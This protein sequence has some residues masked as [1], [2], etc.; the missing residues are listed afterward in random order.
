M[1]LRRRRVVIAAALL[2]ALVLALPWGA[3]RLLWR[4]EQNPVLRGRQAATAQGCLTCHVPDGGRDIPNPGSRWGSVPKFR[5]GNAMMYAEGRA[6]VE[7]FIR[8]GAPRAWLD[9]EDA[10]KRLDAQLVRMPAYGDRLDDRTID[11][12]VA[13]ASAAEGIGLPGGEAAS[14]GRSLARQHGCTSC[15]GIEG[16]GGEP[17][18]GSLGGFVPGFAGRNFPDL[19]RDRA[20]FEEWIRTGTSARLE[21][22]PIVRH[23]W[24]RQTVVMPAYGDALDEEA[25]EQL[26]AWVRA[27]RGE[28]GHRDPEDG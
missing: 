24:R 12:L 18:P 8:L 25:I 15:H 26:W 22:N 9:D 2:L 21:K 7:Q 3:R 17:N 20:E 23:F 10:R 28:A 27:L 4:W 1:I 6:E 11:D 13:F 19:V 14:A 5:A 16:A